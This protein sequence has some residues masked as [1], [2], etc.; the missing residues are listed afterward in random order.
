MEDSHAGIL[1]CILITDGARGILA[2]IIYKEQLEVLI[3]LCQYAV[4]AATQ[5]LLGVIDWNDN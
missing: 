1:G 4:Y 2:A 5:V 3:G